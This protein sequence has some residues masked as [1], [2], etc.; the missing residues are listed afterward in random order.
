[1]RSSNTR[2][3]AVLIIGLLSLVVAMACYGLLESTGNWDNSVLNLGGAIVGFVAAAYMLHH[4]YKNIPVDVIAEAKDQG[5]AAANEEALKILD[6]RAVGREAGDQIVAFSDHYRIKKIGDVKT[7]RLH[8]STNGDGITGSSPT[9]PEAELKEWTPSGPGDH[10]HL[11]K[12]YD[13]ELPFDSV[14]RNQTVPVIVSL[15]YRNA[16]RGSDREWFETHIDRPTAHLTIMILLPAHL[17]ARRASSRIKIGREWRD[18]PDPQKFHSGS[19]IC[20]SV[21]RPV[22][23]AVYQLAWEWAERESPLGT[24]ETT[25]VVDVAATE[26]SRHL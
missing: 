22:L 14:A 11:K 10:K 20:Y 26:K 21:G 16:F 2:E 6:L 18:G 19:I 23:G 24:S 4:I 3:R 12:E 9:H 8:Y 15:Q 25:G 7:I 5:E 1:M 13:L 17:V